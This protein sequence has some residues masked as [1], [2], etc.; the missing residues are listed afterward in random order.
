[1]SFDS[2]MGSPV[3]PFKDDDSMAPFPID[4]PVVANLGNTEM[5]S[6]PKDN[7]A[8]DILNGQEMRQELNLGAPPALPTMNKSIGDIS[9]KTGETWAILIG[10]V[11]LGF[12]SRALFDKMTR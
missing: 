5:T 11:A 8:Q 9:W 4:E 2:F 6:F 3:D 12:I 7:T 10:G 1:M